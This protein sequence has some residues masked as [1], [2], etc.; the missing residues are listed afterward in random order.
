M[1]P[2]SRLWPLLMQSS[3]T[4]WIPL[5]PSDLRVLNPDSPRWPSCSFPLEFSMSFTLGHS[6]LIWYCT[7]FS[8]WMFNDWVFNPNF[9][10]LGLHWAT[11]QPDQ[12]PPPDHLKNHLIWVDSIKVIPLGLK[13]K[14]P[15]AHNRNLLFRLLSCHYHFNYGTWMV[16]HW[17][18]WYEA[19]KLLGDSMDFQE[20]SSEPTGKAK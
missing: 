20:A 2:L 3:L 8:F 12:P 13:Q 15:W 7:L 9:E 14:V 18:G 19:T 16:L 17:S 6:L 10:T 1:V 11:A 4:A 5:E